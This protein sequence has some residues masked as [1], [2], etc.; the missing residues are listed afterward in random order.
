MKSRLENTLM[1]VLLVLHGATA[2]VP[3]DDL[4]ISHVR[5]GDDKMDCQSQMLNQIVEL[6]AELSEYLAEVQQGKVV[7]LTRELEQ[8]RQQQKRL[9]DQE[10]QQVQQIAQT[11]Q[12]LASPLLEAPA[13]PQIEELRAQ[14][15]GA[16][17]EKLRSEQS[18]LMQRE[19]EIAQ[20]L[21][22]EAQRGRTLQERALKLQKAL[23][24]QR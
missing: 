16:I 3:N 1:L 5:A 22:R 14:L 24:D 8:L 4:Q 2:F 13:R 11:E 15:I 18:G 9:Q 6:R 20:R 7:G 23:G 12:Q 17:A 10:L 19:A 21:E